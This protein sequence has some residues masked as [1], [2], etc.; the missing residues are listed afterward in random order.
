[1]AA[2][3]LPGWF[4]KRRLQAHL[5]SILSKSVILRGLV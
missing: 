2:K 3:P 4:L 5:S 1:L